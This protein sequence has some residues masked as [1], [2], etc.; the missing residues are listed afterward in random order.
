MVNFRIREI[1]HT[2]GKPYLLSLIISFSLIFQ[3]CPVILV[4]AGAAAGAG[5]VLYVKGELKVVEV[6]GLKLG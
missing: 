3:G 4:G 2:W 1:T 5:A 6:T